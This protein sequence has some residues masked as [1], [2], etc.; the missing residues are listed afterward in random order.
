MS[1]LKALA[2]VATLAAL[3]VPAGRAEGPHPFKGDRQ[4]TVMTRNLFLGTDLTPIL[5][6]PN[7]PALY[8]AV[9]AAWTQ[10]QANDFPARA[11]AI[12]DEIAAARPDLVGLQEA[13]LFRTDVP[14]DG[15]AT[16]AEDVAYDFVGLLVAALAD[17]GLTYE[18]VSAFT[19]TDA[20]L[21]AGLPPAKDVRLT[22][23]VVVLARADDVRPRL[24]LS[25]PQS[26]AYPT[27]LTVPTAAGPL[28]LPRGWASVDVKLRG[29]SFR[30]V[31]THLE[32]FSGAVRNA[33]AAQ[34][35]AGPAATDLPVVLVGDMNSGPGM[36]MTAYGILTGGGFED[37]WTGGPL[38]C[39]HKVDLHDPSPAMT[40]RIDLV[41]TRGG[42]STVA[43]DVVG[44]DAADRTAGGLW[45]SDHA[46]VAATLRL[47]QQ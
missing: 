33:E 3:A 30:F 5:T 29:R 35:V 14:A 1:P 13:M 38:T 47:P 19:G 32:A 10:V 8:A 24:K 41:L 12:A 45:P 25:N 39:C 40:K 9:G 44:E 7:A 16:P 43:A 31:T 2:V 20:E 18:A 34:L 36:D 27:A 17:R 46:G 23:R 22:D 15:P 37:A 11:G 26:G 21:P 6:A 4:V 42:F 28:T